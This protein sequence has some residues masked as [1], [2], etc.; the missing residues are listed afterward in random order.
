MKKTPKF[1]NSFYDEKNQILTN[2][3]F[4]VDPETGE[5]G[6]MVKVEKTYYGESGWWKLYL[7]QFLEVLGK[8]N[9]NILNVM[10][11]ICENTATGNNIFLGTVDTIAKYCN[12][13]RSTVIRCMNELKDAGFIKMVARGQYMV[14]PKIMYVGGGDKNPGKH[15]FL[16]ELYDGTQVPDKVNPHRRYKTKS[17][18]KKDKGAEK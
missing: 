14:N 1:N 10:C 7:Q 11:F 3:S 9:I 8:F 16:I 18:T 15:G 2:V 12:I 4:P 6:D 5:V 17:L 13:S